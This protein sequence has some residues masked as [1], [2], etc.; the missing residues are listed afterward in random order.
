MPIALAASAFSLWLIFKRYLTKSPLDNLPGPLSTSFLFGKYFS[1]LKGFAYLFENVRKFAVA[2]AQDEGRQRTD[3]LT[4][5]VLA[6]AE[7]VRGRQWE[8]VR[9]GREGLTGQRH[10]SVNPNRGL[11]LRQGR[12]RELAWKRPRR[13]PATKA[14]AVPN[15]LSILT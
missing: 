9:E 5:V 12:A 3:L 14:K 1:L 13:R 11:G 8:E 7:S 15:D 6:Y 10:P 2:E 4:E